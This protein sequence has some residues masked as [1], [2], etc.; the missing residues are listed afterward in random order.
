MN[1]KPTDSN[2]CDLPMTPDHIT[3][4]NWDTSNYDH[5]RVRYINRISN[6]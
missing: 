6:Q 2:Q 1:I 5:Y 3:F 4:Y